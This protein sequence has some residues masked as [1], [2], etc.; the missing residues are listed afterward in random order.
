MRGAAAPR[1]VN[2]CP[3]VTPYTAH[4][5]PSGIY[6]RRSPRQRAAAAARAAVILKEVVGKLTVQRINH[7]RCFAKVN[8]DGI[9]YADFSTG[10]PQEYIEHDNGD[11]VCSERTSTYS[12]ISTKIETSESEESSV[13]PA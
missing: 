1:Y 2:K 6:K 10:R 8:K 4:P 5:G 12:G 3:L 13:E 11:L 9:F 7:V